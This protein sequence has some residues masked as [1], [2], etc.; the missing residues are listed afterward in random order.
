M[1]TT[2]M[3]ERRRSDDHG[4]GTTT[5]TNNNTNNNLTSPFLRPDAAVHG[6]AHTPAT[7]TATAT[8]PSHLSHLSHTNRL[9][10]SPIPPQTASASAPPS[11]RARAIP[12]RAPRIPWPRRIAV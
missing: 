8:A 12:S 4:N 7:A 9:L 2:S 6:T 10:P 3:S 1:I 11:A 5:T